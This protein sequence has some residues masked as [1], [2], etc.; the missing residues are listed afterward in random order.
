MSGG[1]SEDV[2]RVG[3][4][5]AAGLSQAISL[6]VPRDYRDIRLPG[7]DG[8]VTPFKDLTHPSKLNKRCFHLARPEARV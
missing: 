7:M 8:K 3:V 4:V 2:P 5:S 1:I 6:E